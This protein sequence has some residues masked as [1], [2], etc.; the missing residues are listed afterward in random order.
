MMHTST[1]IRLHTDSLMP[2]T[3]TLL[4]KGRCVAFLLGDVIGASAVKAHLSHLT[5][6][7]H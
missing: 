1:N 5:S 2:A 3:Q 4:S 6:I 7:G